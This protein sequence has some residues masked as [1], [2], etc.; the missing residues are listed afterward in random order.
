MKEVLS[1]FFLSASADYGVL[2]G[3]SRQFSFRRKSIRWTE[4][5]DIATQVAKRL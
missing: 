1:R 3:G 2:Q 5:E 4:N